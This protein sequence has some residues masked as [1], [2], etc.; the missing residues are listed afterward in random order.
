M[1]KKTVKHLYSQTLS[2]QSTTIPTAFFSAV[3]KLI[4]SCFQ[5]VF[6][7]IAKKQTN[8]KAVMM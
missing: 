1:K 8:R 7:N 3:I 6:H 2:F 4:F 5:N